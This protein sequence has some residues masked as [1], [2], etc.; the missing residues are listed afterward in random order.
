M[1]S[2]LQISLHLCQ[3]ENLQKARRATT[4]DVSWRV[5]LLHV[6][7]GAQVQIDLQQVACVY[8]GCIAIL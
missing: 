7:Q 6:L 2:E 5:A 1:L 8:T 4:P 3:S